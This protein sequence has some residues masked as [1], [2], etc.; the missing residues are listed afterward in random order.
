MIFKQHENY[1]DNATVQER[2]HWLFPA[3]ILGMARLFGLT[4]FGLSGGSF[5]LIP[6]RPSIGV[7][8][9]AQHSQPLSL[10]RI[11]RVL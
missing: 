1:V 11:S 9:C 3:V 6:D 5:L 7:A 4:I 10:Y 2:F 8:Y